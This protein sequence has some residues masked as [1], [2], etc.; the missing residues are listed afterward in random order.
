MK[1]F[2]NQGGLATRLPGSSQSSFPLSRRK[3][4]KTALQAGAALTAPQIIPSSVLGRDGTVSPSER[5]VLG[6]IGIG[7][8]SVSPSERIVLGAIGIGNRGTY[9]LGC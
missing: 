5:I 6:A 2:V 8:R 7:N 4:L 9:V 1:H 3:F